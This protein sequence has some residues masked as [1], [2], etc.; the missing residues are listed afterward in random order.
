MSFEMEKYFK[1]V[2]PDMAIPVEKVL[3]LNP[4]HPAVRKLKA[5]TAEDP[6]KAKQYA[7]VLYAQGLI[8]ADLPIEDPQAYTELICGLL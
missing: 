7:R 6:E 2:N 8:L 5:L 1:R 4:E 3:R